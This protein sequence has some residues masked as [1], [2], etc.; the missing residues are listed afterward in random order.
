MADLSVKELA[1]QRDAQI[2]KLKQLETERENAGPGETAPLDSLI[3]IVN[4]EIRT[5][6]TLLNAAV[7]SES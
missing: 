7:Q 3:K 5:L 6:D 4:D 1:E 2:E